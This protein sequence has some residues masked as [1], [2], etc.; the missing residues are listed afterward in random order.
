MHSYKF[1]LI[2]I[3]IQGFDDVENS[4]QELFGTSFEKNYQT[5]IGVNV[6]I[7]NIDIFDGMIATVS[8][9]DISE[10]EI[11]KFFRKSL[12]KGATGAIIAFDLSDREFY[13]NACHKILEIRQELSMELPYVLV[14][15]NKGKIDELL[16]LKMLKTSIID[17]GGI[18]FEFTDD[19]SDIFINT[20]V[21]MIQKIIKSKLEICL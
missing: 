8:F 16:D 15:V 11:F 7:K 4:F 9:W 13:K 3:N 1:K 19:S 21:V 17:D 18:F 5:N 10:K 2:F 6:Y 14:G 12:Y 20:I